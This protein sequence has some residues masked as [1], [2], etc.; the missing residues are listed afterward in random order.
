MDSD[1]GVL[2]LR[3]DVALH[4]EVDDATAFGSPLGPRPDGET[5]RR[6]AA[7][8]DHVERHGVESLVARG[9][10][11]LAAAV[12]GGA[13]DGVAAEVGPRGWTLR[14][15]VLHPDP[16]RARPSALVAATA[17]GDGVRLRVEDGLWPEVHSTVAAL[18]GAAGLAP[19][20]ALTPDERVLVQALADAGA[21]E[22]A[23]PLPGD[24]ALTEPG[25][26][27]LGHNGVV[28]RSATTRVVVDP[29]VCPAEPGAPYRPLTLAEVGPL[30]AVVVTHSHPDHFALATL[31]QVPQGTTVV[32]P[33]VERETVLS[34]AMGQRL[35]QLG[36][37]RVVELGW[38]ERCTVGDIEVH[39]LPFLGEQPTD[40]AVLH[41]EIRNAGNTYVIRTPAFSI[42]ALADSGRDGTGDVKDLAVEARERLGPVDVLFC[43]YRAWQL[44]P[45]QHLS[46]SVA[47]Y[48]LFV[49]PALWGCRLQLMNDADDAVDVAERWGARVLVPYADGGAPWFWER[50]LGP[51][52]DE[53]AAE[54][55][56]VDPFPER[57]LAA[58]ARRVQ[59]PSGE[60][61][62]S[63]VPVLLLRPNDSLLGVG[64]REPTVHRLPGNAWPYRPL[65]VVR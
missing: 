53:E 14:D 5:R 64:A 6:F 16:A 10:A 20:T 63:P 59:A 32:V 38:G 44:Y 2:R 13:L 21:V 19:G 9:P 57:V 54:I 22:R 7:V 4:V 61:L 24:R 52:L 47:R 58:A 3:P 28:V 31:L 37:S 51:R 17:P 8:R 15:E 49:P 65:A 35:R 56:S 36:F 30:D 25:L 43:G 18:A 60:W 12:E 62:G 45:V 48:L 27:F 34:V 23:A 41:P 46:S 40:G 29:F 1:G 50:G 11:L 55:E 39:A 26:T 42:A 33:R